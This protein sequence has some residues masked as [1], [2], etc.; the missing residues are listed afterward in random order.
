SPLA[1]DEST[2]IRLPW[3]PGVDAVIA[4]G[5]CHTG[6]LSGTERS[7]GQQGAAA[8]AQQQHARRT[9]RRLA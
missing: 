3:R 2:R 9:A 1:V 8:F 4:M 5:I 6:R 7:S